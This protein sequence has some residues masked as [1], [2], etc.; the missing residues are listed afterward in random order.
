MRFSSAIQEKGTSIR[1]QRKL[2]EDW[3]KTKGVDLMNIYQDDGK[4]A[5]N[6]AKQDERKEFIQMQQDRQNNYLPEPIYLLVEDASR[7]SRLDFTEATAQMKRL[8]EMGFV[9]VFIATGKVYSPTNFRQLGD[10]ISFLVDAETHH[11]AS[12]QKSH[13][14]RR[15][16]KQLRDDAIATGK[17]ISRSC[18]RWCVPVAT[19]AGL[20]NDSGR[21]TTFIFNDHAKTVKR[22]FA[23]R[24]AGDSMNT[25]SAVLN[26]ESIPTLTG[27]LNAWNQTTIHG[28]LNNRAVTGEYVPSLKT[29]TED[30]ESIPGYYPRV[31]SDSDF[32]TVQSMREGK[33]R[34][35]DSDNPTNINLFKGI[36][37]CVCG[38]AIISSSVTPERY[39]YYSCSMYRLKRCT[40]METDHLGKGKG[41]GKK[42]TGVAI[43]RQLV[44]EAIVKGLLYQLPLLLSGSNNDNNI[45]N[46][47]EAEAALI[48]QQL[49][50]LE[51]NM[52]S[53]QSPRLQKRYAETEALL[54]AKHKQIDE[55]KSRMLTTA[56]VETVNHLDLSTREGRV[57]LNLIAKKYLKVITLDMKKK[58]CDI[59]LHN[60]MKLFNYPV[61]YI[62]DGDKWVERLQIIGE[63]EFTFSGDETAAPLSVML[64]R[65]TDA[66]R[67]Q[68]ETEGGNL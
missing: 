25:I 65:A 67:H 37:K 23:M 52:M 43:Q 7:L 28:I 4:S 16:W 35:S 36:L 33:G 9:V 24:I 42:G 30:A 14:S 62:L 66:E 19:G 47:L 27:K 34:T 50:N 59:E 41:R 5:W 38:G 49:D 18:A 64:E 39:G 11:K 60:G 44:D 21:N 58:T 53:M 29:V 20:P 45:L 12:E 22:I 56:C 10:H 2:I 3:C 55:H 1:R 13:H 6:V 48:E 17:L 40:C 57:E 46:E 32:M 68:F 26:A 54:L 31:V 8:I 61:S 63:T 51:Q 15:N